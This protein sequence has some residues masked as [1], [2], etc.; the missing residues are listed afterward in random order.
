MGVATTRTRKNDP[1]KTLDLQ[2]EEI[3][4]AKAEEWVVLINKQRNIRKARVLAIARDIIEGNWRLTGEAF[5]FDQ[6]GNFVDGQHRAHALILAD[7]EKPGVTIQAVV[8]RNVPT[9]AMTVMD[10]GAART[11]G[12]QLSIRDFKNPALLAAAA[13]WV[14]LFDRDSLY[15]ERATKLVTH[16]EIYR[17]VQNNPELQPIVADVHLNLRRHIDAM[18]PATIAA[19]Y[20]ICWRVNPNDAH[21]FFERLAS[22]VG[23]EKD[24]PLLALRSRLR[25]LRNGHVSLPPEG[26]LSLAIRTW[27]AMRE[28]QRMSSISAFRR[29]VPVRCPQPV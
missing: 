29:G 28:G 3:D 5:K 27:N 26:Y 23:L 10:T 7:K 18:T 6:D 21:Y 22:G 2:V 15:G 12:D 14:T 24:D 9:E 1:G 13:K 16:S 17:F 25:E 20:Y 4:A 8:A 11:A 19:A